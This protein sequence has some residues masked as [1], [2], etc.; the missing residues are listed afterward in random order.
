MVGDGYCVGIADKSDIERISEIL[1]DP[2]NEALLPARTKLAW[3]NKSV[4][5]KTYGDYR[6]VVLSGSTPL[7]DGSGVTDAKA[8]SG[9]PSQGGGFEVSM[10]MDSKH[11]KMWAN[12]TA[13]NVGKQIAIV[14]DDVVYSAPVVNQRIT[15]GESVISGNFSM[16]EAEDLASILRLAHLPFSPAVVSL[17]VRER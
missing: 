1:K 9:D 10:T 15:G 17:E 7:M 14:M 4:D 11:T 16:Q 8:Q 6:L 13:N 3:E 5:G 2:K 12:I